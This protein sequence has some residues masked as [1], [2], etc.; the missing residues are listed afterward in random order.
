MPAAAILGERTAA[1]IPDEATP[2]GRIVLARSTRV[3]AVTAALLGPMLPL[4]LLAD[5]LARARGV[6]PD[7]LGREDPA[8][9]AAHG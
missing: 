1:S 4:Q 3:T 9:A 5:R 8:Q 7:T 6:N 2:A